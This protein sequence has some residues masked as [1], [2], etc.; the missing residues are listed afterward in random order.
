MN[1]EEPSSV[2]FDNRRLLKLFKPDSLED[3][4][5]PPVIERHKRMWRTLCHLRIILPDGERIKPLSAGVVDDW[6]I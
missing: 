3:W 4:A 2:S 1:H 5:T 6:E